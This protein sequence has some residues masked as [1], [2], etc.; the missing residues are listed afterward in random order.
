[1]TAYMSA[2]IRRMPDQGSD[3]DNF[4]STGR[5]LRLTDG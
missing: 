3:D 5:G 4:E 1:M 2:S